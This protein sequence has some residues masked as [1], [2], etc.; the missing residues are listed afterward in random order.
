MNYVLPIDDVRAAYPNF[1]IVKALTPSAQKAAFH[2]KDSAGRDICLKIISPDY[3]ID[4][5][6]REI[7]AL[8]KI[9]HPNIVRL[10]EYQYH[11][12]T[13]GIKHYMVE[14]F[15]D[16]S[17]LEVLLTGKMTAAV[18]FPL[19]AQIADGLSELR[20]QDIVHRDIKP[21][22]IRVRPDGKP[23]IIDFGVARHLGMDALT[24]TSQGAGLGTPLYFAPEQYNGTKYDIDHRTDLFAFGT[25]LYRAVCG[26][27]PFL[28]PGMTDR[29][30]LQDAVCNSAD[31]ETRPDF[32]ALSA[33][34]QLLLKKLLSKDRAGRPQDAS[35]VA[36]ILRKL[37]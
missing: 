23:V 32:L 29:A 35:Q 26:E 7:L 18:A 36:M 37:S 11:V 19:F 34:A 27:Q 3:N 28:R 2:A 15:I 4:R 21:E 6:G 5:L 10:I 31:H 25:I 17:D 16:G 24:R 9:T 30:Q 12:S 33:S 20:K 13:A 14:E 1:T 22:N 8:Q